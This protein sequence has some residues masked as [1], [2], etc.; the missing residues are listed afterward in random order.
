MADQFPVNAKT[1]L[2]PQISDGQPRLE[3]KTAAFLATGLGLPGV[4]WV[5]NASAHPGK[6]WIF[7]AVT[8]CTIAA[9]TYAPGFGSGFPAGT[10]LKAGD[11]IYGQII[12]LTLT[13]G[14]GELYKAAIT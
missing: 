6:W 2:I 1:I 13:S 4:E 8:D 3:F 12:S 10:V 9:I 5:N 11:R 14:T 7:H